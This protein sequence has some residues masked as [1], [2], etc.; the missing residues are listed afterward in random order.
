[1]YFCVPVPPIYY[2]EESSEW[3]GCRS[4]R[5]ETGSLRQPGAAFLR[6][7]FI[8]TLETL[9]EILRWSGDSLCGEPME[10][11][12]RYRY[13]SRPKMDNLSVERA[14]REA[15]SPIFPMLHG[16]SLFVEKAS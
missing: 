8:A 1:M 11:L 4:R 6:E 9:E 12:T 14:L 3:M 16:T 2:I 15:A 13:D 10:R 7:A 5:Y